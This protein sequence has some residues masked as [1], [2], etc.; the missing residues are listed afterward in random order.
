MSRSYISMTTGYVLATTISVASFS[1]AAF[2]E[3]L[4]SSSGGKSSFASQTNVLDTRA[5]QQ[6]A[7]STRLTPNKGAE[8]SYG[9]PSFNGKYKGEFLALAK[10]AA[11]K[12]GIPQDL[13]LRLVQQESGWNPPCA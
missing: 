8:P 10:S 3:N 13:F 6:Y 7:A 12:H 9:I 4:F 11:R 5:S 2:A 1:S